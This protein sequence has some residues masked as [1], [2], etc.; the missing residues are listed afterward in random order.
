M[1]D[2]NPRDKEE[3][4][5][6]KRALDLLLLKSAP[7]PWTMR[8]RDSIQ[9]QLRTDRTHLYVY[10]GGFICK[11]IRLFERENRNLETEKC[12]WFLNIYRWREV[13]ITAPVGSRV[14]NDIRDDDTLTFHGGQRNRIRSLPKKKKENS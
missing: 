2:Q 11:D 10:I 6:L 13:Y 1:R 5:Y 14:F 3:E 8:Q 9:F 7:L 12:V 4:N